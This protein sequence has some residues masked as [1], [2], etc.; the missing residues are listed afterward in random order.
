MIG[1]IVLGSCMSATGGGAVTR[2]SSETGD[3]ICSAM[4]LLISA[5]DSRDSG[6]I[7]ISWKTCG[8]SDHTLASASPPQ[9]RTRSTARSESS[10]SISL[11]ETW[12]NSGG[13]PAQLPNSGDTPGSSTKVPAR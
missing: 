8:R 11:P 2:F 12:N 1:S 9:A 13:R 5:S 4:N 10:S 6:S 3:A 7:S